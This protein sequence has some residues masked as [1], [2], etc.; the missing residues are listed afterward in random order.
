M[1]ATWEHNGHELLQS[2]S[3]VMAA[4]GTAFLPDELMDLGSLLAGAREHGLAAMMMCFAGDARAGLSL[5]RGGFAP[6]LSMPCAD[7][8]SLDPLNTSPTHSK[9]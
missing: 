4:R 2:A 5:G 1:T 3:E 8:S 7:G 6:C 9:T